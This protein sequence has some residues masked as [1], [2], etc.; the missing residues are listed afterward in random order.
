MAIATTE[1]PS[2]E[3]VR[4]RKQGLLTTPLAEP[5]GVPALAER[6]LVACAGWQ[7]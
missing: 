6:W 5:L 4:A 1:M 2:A 7:I 3:S